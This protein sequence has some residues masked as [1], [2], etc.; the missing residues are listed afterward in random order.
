MRVALLIGFSYDGTAKTLPGIIIDLY[1]AYKLA[2]QSSVDKLIIITDIENDRSTKVLFDAIVGGLVDGQILSFIETI[3]NDKV[4]CSYSDIQQIKNDISFILKDADECIIYYTGHVK[5]GY[6]ELP[7]IIKIE[8]SYIDDDKNKNENIDNGKSEL[9][10][11][12]YEFYN[13]I[14]FSVSPS[15]QILLIM[16]CCHGSG[17][18]LPFKLKNYH[19]SLTRYDNP[20]Y[21][22]QNIIYITSTNITERAVASKNGSLFSRTLFKQLCNNQRS[23][24]KILQNLRSEHKLQT[25]MV[26]SNLANNKFIWNWL[27]FDEPKIIVNLDHNIIIINK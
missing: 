20:I 23:L 11:S 9:K 22:K 8:I 16:D 25:A 2:K 24:V 10:Y 6:I 15:S 14:F 18:N 21:P 4:Y 7:E 12:L 13:N 3:K 5:L 27:Y 1:L 26:Y 19:Y 17:L